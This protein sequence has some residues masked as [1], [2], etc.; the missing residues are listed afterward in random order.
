MSQR[1]VKP[2]DIKTLKDW[3]KRWPKSGNLEFD[4]ETRE[5]VVYNE[6]KRS[7]EGRAKVATI[8]WKR[9]FDILS[10]V[11]APAKYSEAVA[12]AARNRI[13][14]LDERKNELKRTME[15]GVRTHETQLLKAWRDYRAD[16]RESSLQNVLAAEKMLSDIEVAYAPRDRSIIKIDGYSASY[17]PSVPLNQRALPIAP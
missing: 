13:G 2:A 10:V 5:P 9:E 12:T 4:A 11:A 1:T 7:K 16:P 15:E 6:I 14:V 8:P 17:I 3:V